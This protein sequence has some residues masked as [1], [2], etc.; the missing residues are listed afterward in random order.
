MLRSRIVLLAATGMT[1]RMIAQRV[2]SQDTARK[3]RRRYCEQGIEGLADAPRPGRP[4][5][6]PATVVAEVKALACE[7]PAASRT[8]LAR[9]TCPELA[10]HAAAVGIV[11]APSASTVRRWLTDDALKPWQH[12]SWI[13]PR[14]PH[15]ALKASRVLDLY[16]R[17][18]EG[19]PLGQD[20]YV[21]SADEKPGVQARMRIHLPLPPGPGR[22][23]RIEG[24]Y[25]R[26]GTL[27]YLAAYDVH[28][29]RIMGRCEPTTGIKPFTALV[30]Q[31]MQSEPFTS[32]RRVFWIVDNGSSHR[33]WAA[34]A[35]LS[36][37]YPNAQMVHLP[38]HASWLNQI[39]VY[40]SVI[41]RKLLTP[42][43]FEDLDELTA[44][45][46][47]FESHYNTTA[48]PFDW[49]FTRTDLNRLLAR[50]RQH[51]RHAPQPLAA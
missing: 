16:Q 43:D 46:L 12:R 42:D 10:R 41:Q 45:I 37:A 28:Q 14:D 4:R 40:C 47:A 32:A 31:V 21:L 48:R 29:A 35:R 49:K 1:N 22:A 13:F 38:V 11:P 19:A 24:E 2:D 8:P 34:A 15:F 44:Q 36:D 50:I 20:E 27:A 9:W 18:W 6:Y 51:D 33:N 7:L 23:M 3:W 26:F 25:H 30:D 39:E 5:L 17:Q